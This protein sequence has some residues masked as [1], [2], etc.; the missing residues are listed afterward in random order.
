MIIAWQIV[1]RQ[2][3][4]LQ[5]FYAALFGWIVGDRLHPNDSRS[6]DDGVLPSAMFVEPLESA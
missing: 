1:T 2:P 3:E 4:K 5:F 6:A